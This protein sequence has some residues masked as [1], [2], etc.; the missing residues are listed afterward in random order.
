M[1][2]TRDQNRH[3]WFSTN[4]DSDLLN[5]DNA[6]SAGLDLGIGQ[7]LEN[8]NFDP[9]NLGIPDAELANLFP[10]SYEDIDDFLTQELKDLDIPMIPQSLNPRAGSSSP[11]R[12]DTVW[13]RDSNLP[14]GTPQKSHKR[15][16]SGTAI[17][18]F[19]NHNKQLS[20]TKNNFDE[21]ILTST[22]QFG[23][24]TTSYDAD[25]QAQNN[26]L[27]SLILKQQEELRLA[28]ER[29]QVMNAQLEE[30]LRSSQRQQQQLQM[31]LKEQE[32]AAQHLTVNVSPAKTPSSRT[33][34]SGEDGKNIIVTSNSKSGGYQFPAPNQLKQP[35]PGM[36]RDGV[37]SPVS[38]TSM[39][40]SPNRKNCNTR[41]NT[42]PLNL[43]VL[44][45]FSDSGEDYSSPE[46]FF[47]SSHFK[48][49]ISAETVQKMSKYFE[50]VNAKSAAN[51]GRRAENNNPIT[52]QNRILVGGMS[53]TSS[54]PQATYH[55]AKES[56]SSSASTIPQLCD[57]DDRQ[58][59]ISTSAGRGPVG[60]GIRSS[61][62]VSKRKYL[63]NKPPPLELLP[64]I[65]GSSENTPVNKKHP[66]N[67]D[68][69][70]L[71]QKHIFQHTP[72]KATLD[73]S[74]V[75]Y[76]NSRYPANRPIFETLNEDLRPPS[77]EER[78]YDDA[79]GE[80]GT[81]SE[82]KYAQTPSPILRS[83]GRFEDS[84]PY[85]SHEHCEDHCEDCDDRGECHPDLHEHSS[86]HSSPLKITKKPTTLP[87]GQIDK[88][89]LELP[90][91]SFK[92]LYPGCGK[93]FKRRYNIRS[94]IQT[95]LEDRPYICDYEGCDKAFVRNHDLVRHKKIHAE[96]SF[97]CPCGKKF[98]R[99]DALIVHRCRM[100]CVGGKKFNNIV[101]KKSPRR[102]GRPRKDGTF[103]VTSS[104]VKESIA[105]NNH[106]TIALQMEE[107]LQRDM[108]ESGLLKPAYSNS[109]GWSEQS[110]WKGS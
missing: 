108:I 92:C 87:P 103:S 90:D 56:I 55:R 13:N 27:N 81:E 32:Y 8:K 17:F 98:V 102:R 86:H 109:G 38:G 10:S 68:S 74:N 28:L 25:Y 66:G 71:P 23:A 11:A 16:P 5:L 18:G 64:T 72:T 37:I 95:H 12:C 31:A 43:N 88:Y 89:V 57:D 77:E 83:Q 35:N 9:S 94:H 36:S 105:R 39:N 85:L 76:S 45:N 19:A 34:H 4:N 80:E 6:D 73:P 100:I 70:S 53:S 40:G 61:N 42:Q 21:N 1:T 3:N 44:N 24:P 15:G 50:H 54:S 69:G 99:E 60:L 2:S 26:N 82:F 101:I 65:P 59:H 110:E 79:E 14:S 67:L 51:S 33:S 78:N 107:Q 96:K 47:G 91:K 75:S 93:T 52:P 30:Q 97:T 58:S 22:N 46:N 29:Q 84:S 41:H 48:P 63:L 7:T 49:K 104:P 62:D 20:L 106:E